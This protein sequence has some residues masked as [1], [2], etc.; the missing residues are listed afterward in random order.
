MIFLADIV[1]AFKKSLKHL[2]WMDEESS[3]AAADKARGICCLPML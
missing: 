3:D 1:S 2:E